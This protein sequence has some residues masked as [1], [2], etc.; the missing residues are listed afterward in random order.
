M[1]R[2]QATSIRA[3]GAWA[4]VAGCLALGLGACGD[5]DEETTGGETGGETTALTKNA[6][7][8]QASEICASTNRDLRQIQGPQE[9]VSRI[10]QGLVNLQALPAPEGDEAQV[11]KMLSALEQAIE[12]DRQAQAGDRPGA[13]DEDPYVEFERLA[14]QFGVE[15]GCT[16]A[17]L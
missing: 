4:L 10:E 1:G 13:V 17:G 6:Y 15:G 8:E 7:I 2:M 5:D 11:D 12:A 3:R 14:Q 9:A 16:H